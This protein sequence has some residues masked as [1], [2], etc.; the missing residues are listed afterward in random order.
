MKASGY[1]Q[2]LT[3]QNNATLAKQLQSSDAIQR[4][5]DAAAVNDM[6]TRQTIGTQRAD[7]G[8]SG[9]NVDSGSAA[10][11]A[12]QHCGRWSSGF[13]QHPK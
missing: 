3:D 10:A 12:N 2:N 11:R 9:V 13:A 5:N 7:M 6:K 1:T 4:G 8:A